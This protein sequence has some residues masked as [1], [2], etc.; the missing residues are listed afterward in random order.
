MSQR[1]DV[2]VVVIGARCAGAAHARLLAEA[3][4]STLVVDRCEEGSDTLS[5]HTL[6]RGA[7][8]QLDRWDMLPRLVASGTPGISRSVFQFGET[9][10]PLDLRPVRSGPGMVAPRR[11]KLDAMLGTAAREAGAELRY[12]TSFR[13]TIRDD[14]GR[15]RGVRLASPEGWEYSVRA[16]F[17]VGADGLRSALAR[18]VGARETTITEACHS[19]LYGYFVLPDQRDNLFAF[20]PGLSIGLTPTDGGVTTVIVSGSPARLRAEISEKGAEG[21]ILNLASEIDAELGARLRAAQMPERARLF[22]GHATIRR[23]SSGAGWALIG[24]A[25]QFRDPVT[26]HGITDAFRDAEHLALH[27]LES[28]FDA[29][30]YER[31]RNAVSDPIFALT[32]EMTRY[33]RPLSELSAQFVRLSQLMRDEQAWM[34]ARFGARAMAA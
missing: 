3:G 4:V 22:A 5:S 25:G 32:A 29:A 17:V 28:G 2:D 10:I 30:G 16:D 18:S 26:A 27:L 15:V 6:T 33:D 12:R 34:E 21:A 8:K 31:E 13:D 19:H 7:V 24:D 20:A 11:S 1:R 23:Q 14:A 9:T